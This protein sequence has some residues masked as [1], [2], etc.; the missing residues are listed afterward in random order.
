[1]TILSIEPRLNGLRRASDVPLSPSSVKSPSIYTS[2][3]PAV[4]ATRPGPSNLLPRFIEQF[5][6]LEDYRSI[7]S[8]LSYHRRLTT[9]T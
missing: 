8:Y 7:Y 2:G 1:M 3:A 6:E 9:S 4:H 5:R